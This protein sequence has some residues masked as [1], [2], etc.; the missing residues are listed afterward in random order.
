MIN[1]NKQMTYET[2]ENMRGGDGTVTLTPIFKAGDYES[3]TRL[4]SRITLPPE[5]SIGYHKHEGEEEFFYIL[6]G[7]G[8]FNDNGEIR[9]VKAGDGTVTVSG[10]GHAI[11]NT[12]DTPLEMVAVIVKIQK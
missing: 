6:S 4:F 9:T 8:E 11:R 1:Y 7:N 5:A 10:Q 12:G 2:R 3:M